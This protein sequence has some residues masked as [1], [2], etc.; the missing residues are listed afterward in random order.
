MLLFACYLAIFL[1]IFSLL[2]SRCLK[3]IIVAQSAASVFAEA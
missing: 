1:L 2:G 3:K